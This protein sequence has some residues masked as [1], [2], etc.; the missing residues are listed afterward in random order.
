MVRI[1]A[2]TLLQMGQG[3]L[4]PEQIPAILAAKDRKKAGPTLP[5]EGLTLRKI[6]YES[7]EDCLLER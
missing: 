1:L 7:E 5:P 3:S 2:G 6:Q 4:Q